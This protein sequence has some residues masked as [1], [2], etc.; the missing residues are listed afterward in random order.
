M[1][2]YVIPVFSF[3]ISQDNNPMTLKE[4][5]KKLYPQYNPLEQKEEFIS[6]NKESLSYLHLSEEMD[7]FIHE[8]EIVLGTINNFLG[9][10]VLIL[11]IDILDADDCYYICINKDANLEN[12]SFL[13]VLE[14]SE[15]KPEEFYQNIKK[16]FDERIKEL[17]KLF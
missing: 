12:I 8:Y 6:R 16:R 15:S 14:P 17:S 4:K 13:C 7:K 9:K 3:L 1:V 5:I 10:E 11:G 2:F